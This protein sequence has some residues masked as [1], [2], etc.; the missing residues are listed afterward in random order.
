MEAIDLKDTQYSWLGSIPEE[1]KKVSL[2]YLFYIQKGRK[3]SIEYEEYQDGLLPYLSMDVLR[4]KND[5]PVYTSPLEDK[6]LVLASEEDILILWDGS[7][8]GEFV[9][10]TKGALSSTMARMSLINQAVDQTFLMYYL[11]NSESY[12][13]N[14]TIG[15]GIPHV[16]GDVLRNL[17]IFLP[18]LPEQ[19]QIARF[20]DHQTGL[21]DAVIAKKETLIKK[22]KEQRQATIN[23][24]VT[25]GLNPNTP[26]K[27]SGIP[28][29]GEIPEHW[30]V[31]RLKYLLSDK[32]KYGANEAA[33]ESNPNDPRYI[34]IT[35]FGNDGEL[36]DN[37][38]RSLPYDQAEEYFLKEGDILFARSGATVGKT[39]QFKNYSGK[40]CYA[41]YLIKA[42]VNKKVSSDYLYLFTKSGL[43]ENWKNSI[44]I[45]ATIQN[46]SADK[47]NGLEI[48]VPPKEEQQ[49]ITKFIL[50]RT[51]LIDRSI[52]VI[53]TQIDKLRE[54]RQSLI[55]EAVTGKIDVREWKPKNN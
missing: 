19:K 14:N 53:Q 10:G 55:S 48:T 38:F 1:W 25:K 20:I 45:Q 51:R 23:E 16:D 11:K 49:E 4:G 18:S 17:P 13:Q 21:I 52:C 6:T 26:L 27:D 50:E 2:K 33:T 37:T 12:I 39:F 30:E 40:A 36:R 15:M 43:Y 42:S 5:F 24:A 44:F 47:Y 31:V 8:A 54:Y 35:D 32:L 34:R 28:W 41:G 46:I 22:L 9:P 7:K 3:P 29:L